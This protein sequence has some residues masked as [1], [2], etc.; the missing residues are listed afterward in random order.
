MTIDWINLSAGVAK[1][2]IKKVQ[3]NTTNRVM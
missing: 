2:F 1:N 3:G